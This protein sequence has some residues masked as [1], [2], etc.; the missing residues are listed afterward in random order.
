MKGKT[1]NPGG[2]PTDK[3]AERL[4]EARRNL[5]DEDTVEIARQTIVAMC[6]SK[7]AKPE[8][9]LKAAEIVLAYAL[10]KPR[11]QAELP[12]SEGRHYEVTVNV[13]SERPINPPQPQDEMVK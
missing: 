7:R 9:R 10:G 8:T 6:R 5:F 3:E 13:K 11:Q 2:R 1:N 12:D 4:R